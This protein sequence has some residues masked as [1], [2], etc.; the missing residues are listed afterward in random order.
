M[1]GVINQGTSIQRLRQRLALALQNN[2]DRPRVACLRCMSAVEM[3]TSTALHPT[4]YV[5]HSAKE[6]SQQILHWW[7]VVGAGVWRTAGAEAR[8][9]DSMRPTH[10]VA[11]GKREE[12]R[13]EAKRIWNR[14]AAV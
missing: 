9:R 11:H 7:L 2:I 13:Q 3:R 8:L 5:H 14:T 4:Q 6:H 12:Y 10:N 1:T